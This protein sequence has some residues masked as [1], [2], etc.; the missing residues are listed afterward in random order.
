MVHHFTSST[1][2]LTCSRGLKSNSRSREWCSL[3]TH[4][5][6]HT[7]TNTNTESHILIPVVHLQEVMQG[8][9]AR[10]EATLLYITS[11]H[12][13]LESLS[14]EQD[15]EAGLQSFQPYVHLTSLSLIG[16]CVCVQRVMVEGLLSERKERCMALAQWSLWTLL[17]HWILTFSPWF[18]CI[19]L[20][21]HTRGCSIRWADAQGGEG[22]HISH[23]QQMKRF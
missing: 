5:H 19:S 17:G 22:S 14:A 18:I 10:R 16:V 4:T 9:C 7:N 6:T 11:I 15:T 2:C 1:C 8:R 23:S 21:A 12:H 3:S 13:V 20:K